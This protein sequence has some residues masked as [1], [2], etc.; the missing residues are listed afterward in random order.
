ML[1][2]KV[3]TITRFKRFVMQHVPNGSDR[4][5]FLCEPVRNGKWEMAYR[6]AGTYPSPRIQ[7]V[8]PQDT[9]KRGTGLF[10]ESDGKTLEV[11]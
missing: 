9:S 6:G 2:I 3:T 5:P 10:T 7:S 11:V 1:M 4:R 8:G